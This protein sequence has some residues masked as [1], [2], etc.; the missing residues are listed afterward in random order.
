M[1]STG[2]SAP[3]H[4]ASCA[5]AWCTNMPRPSSTRRTGRGGPGQPRG[6]SRRIDQV[7]RHLSGVQQGRGHDPFGRR[8]GRARH[9]HRRGVDHQ[10]GRA[11]GLDQRLRRQGHGPSPRTREAGGRRGAGSRPVHHGHLG[12]ARLRQGEHHRP[13]RAT[14]AGDQTAAPRRV[15]ADAPGQRGHEAGAVGV[16]PVERVVAA[17]DAVH[18][19][20][21]SGVLA[22]LL[23]QCRH[24]RLVRH[25]DRQAGHV[26]PPH[27][28]QRGG[29]FSRRDL[30]RE[31]APAVTQ[32]QGGKG[33]VVQQ[34]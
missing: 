9:P 15:E 30:E 8:T 4:R 12:R 17:G 25:R 33:G 20:E 3:V 31:G 18:R 11:D 34:G 14:G 19:P 27:G 16:R 28:L 32:S 10:I 2:G 1:A 5:A 24:R 26:V 29:R 23:E 13:G 21:P 6:G 22:A 7:G